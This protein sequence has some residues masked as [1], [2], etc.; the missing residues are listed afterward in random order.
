MAQSRIAELAAT[1]AANTKQVDDFFAS[2]GL[3]T[4]SFEP[5]S[6]SRALLDGRVAAP[7]QAIL[8]ATDELHALVLGPISTIMTQPVRPF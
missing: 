6:P 3:P 5:D 7:R 8:E 2:Q 1:I 4:P